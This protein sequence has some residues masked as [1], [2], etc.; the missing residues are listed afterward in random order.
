MLASERVL[1]CLEREYSNVKRPPRRCAPD[2]GDGI[3]DTK[4]YNLQSEG[5]IIVRDKNQRIV[6][7]NIEDFIPS[8][9]PECPLF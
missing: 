9:F 4:H 2:D 5:Y 3:M 6:N 8:T 7:V 1:T